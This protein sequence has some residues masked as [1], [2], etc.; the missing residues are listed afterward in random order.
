M[1]EYGHKANPNSN[2]FITY[3]CTFCIYYYYHHRHNNYYHT[4]IEELIT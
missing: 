3:K 2:V 4:L 1:R